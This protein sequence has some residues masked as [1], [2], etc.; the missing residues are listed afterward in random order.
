LLLRSIISQ[1]Q[2]SLIQLSGTIEA[3]ALMDSNGGPSFLFTLQDSDYLSTRKLMFAGGTYNDF[4]RTLN[5]SFLEVKQED[6]T[7]NVE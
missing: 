6:L 1:Y 3:D 7:I 2:E 4:K 5:G